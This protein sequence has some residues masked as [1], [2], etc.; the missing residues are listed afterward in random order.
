MTRI[1]HNLV[2]SALAL[3]LAAGAATAETLRPNFD[4]DKFVPRQAID[5]KYYP[6]TPGER[7][8]LIAKGVDDEGERFRIKEVLKVVTSPRS[9]IAG[10]RVTAQLDKEW[11][12]G[13]LQEKT[14]DYY[15]QDKR[16][17]VWY[18]GEDVTNYRYDDDGNLIG[19]DSESAWIAGRRGAR[20]GWIMPARQ[21]IGQRYFQEIARRDEALDKAKTHAVLDR[22]RIGDTVYRNVLRVLETNP[23]EPNDREFKYYAP[24]VGLIRIEEGLNK[25]LKDPEVVYNRRDDGRGSRAARNDGR[26]SAD[27]GRSSGKGGS[28]SDKRR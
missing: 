16:G 19:T 28:K 24:R 5:N 26:R 18:M 25:N 2:P 22:L 4:T 9:R 15:A 3:T 10:V 20:P 12:N 23:F 14:Y 7:A 13:L 1:M 27:R 6:V 11:E 17:N 21:I 8:V